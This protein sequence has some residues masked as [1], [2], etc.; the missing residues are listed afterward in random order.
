MRIEHIAVWT[1][2][3]DRFEQFYVKYFGATAA[4]RYINPTE[5]FESVF[6][7]FDDGARLEAMRTTQLSPLKIESGAQRL[8]LT[9][10]AVSAG[11]DSAVDQLTQLLK[12]DGYTVLGGPR[13][14]GDGYYESEVLDPDG[15][16][17][18]ITA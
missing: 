13:R 12:V 1:T 4:P 3:L 18:E 7:S 5:G 11:S 8:G 15:N 6:L 17:I 9:H 14:T 16:R 2:D 10:I